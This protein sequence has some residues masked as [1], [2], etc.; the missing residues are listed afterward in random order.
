M[1]C[2]VVILL[3]GLIAQIL[4]DSCTVSDYN[5][6]ATAAKTCDTLTLKDIEIPS[7][8]TM[9]IALKDGA[10]LVFDGHVTHVV[11]EWAGDLVR[12]TGKNVL[13]TGTD[14]HLLDGLG[15][16]HWKGDSETTILRPKFMRFKLNDSHIKNL[17]L[18]N[19]PNN[20][21]LLSGSNNL[22]TNIHVD[23]YDGY[24]GVAGKKYAKNTDGFGV[25]GT[26]NTILNSKVVN[27]DDCIVVGGG[28]KLT[29]QNIHCNGS[30]GL[31]LSVKGG[32]VSDV[33]FLDS[34]IVYANNAIH[35]K[36]NNQG[37]TGSIKNILYK[38]IEFNH[39]DRYAVSIQENYPSGE[40]KAN[41]PITNL[42]LDNVYGS[43]TGKKSV[44]MQII[45][46]TGGCADW[47][48]KDVKVSGAKKS[49]VCQDVPSGISC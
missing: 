27:Q 12:I 5:N 29:F 46:A 33:Q 4:A 1:A 11:A 9:T 34:K 14:N 7:E 37:S 28:S 25:S 23:N 42:T 15:P 30:H 20:C 47:T 43:M 10:T 3:L 22:V 19:C 35:I 38:N 24:P 48:F 21:F 13:V 32:D 2:K 31:S 16:K 18:K 41:I 39:I 26:N 44:A 8:T 36:T 6:V 17:K 45:C 40:A 49:N